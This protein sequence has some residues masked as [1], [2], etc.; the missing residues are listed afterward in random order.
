MDYITSLSRLLSNNTHKPQNYYRPQIEY[1]FH[2]FDR[3]GVDRTTKQLSRIIKD[4][5][6]NAYDRVNEKYQAIVSLNPNTPTNILDIGSGDAQITLALAKHYNLNSSNV[7]VLDDKSP[8]N[9]D[10]TK[11]YRTG[12]TIPLPDQSVDLIVLFSV[13][14]HI[15]VADRDLLLA[16]IARVLSHTGCIII[17]EHDFDH[18]D[19]FRIYCEMLHIIWYLLKH[20]TSDPLVLFSLYQ[21]DEMFASYNLSRI[22]YQSYNVNNPQRLYYAVYGRE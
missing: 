10:Y 4:G 12:D 15:P 18:T 22:R 20:E 19:S 17:R 11:L 3:L 6:I 9:S 21:A 2:H 13:L 5:K 1:L 7:Y 14:H 16:E 8:E